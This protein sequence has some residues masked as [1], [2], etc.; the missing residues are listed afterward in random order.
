MREIHEDK[1]KQE[2][3][4]EKVGLQPCLDQQIKLD[5]TPE[6]TNDILGDSYS[7]INW[8]VPGRRHK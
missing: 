1:D 2:R 8:E 6:K 4:M 7:G 3:F 5:E